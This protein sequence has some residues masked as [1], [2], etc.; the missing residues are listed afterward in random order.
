M[1][2]LCYADLM[3]APEAD[4]HTLMTL[5]HLRDIE[6]R[7]GRQIAIVS[8][9]LDS[10]NRDL[11]EAARADDFIVSDRLT[12][13]MLAQVSENKE[14]L[15]VFADLF[16]ASGSE[17]YLKP[18]TDYV[19]AGTA[20]NFYTVLEAAQRRGEIAI[21]YRRVQDA[22]DAAKYYGVVVNPKKSDKITF[23]AEDKIIVLADS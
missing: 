20:V 13:L 4:A 12:S 2:L 1:I 19:M 10:R 8:E 14:L 7:S 11:A 3:P 18:A 15:A 6:D 9:M 5:L 23:S 22:N 21:G 16:D 17:L